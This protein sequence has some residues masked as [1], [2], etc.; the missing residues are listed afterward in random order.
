MA[1]MLTGTAGTNSMLGGAGDDKMSGLAGSDN[2]FGN[3]GNDVLN[4]GA[5]ADDLSGGAGSDRAT[6]ETAAAGVVASLSS[7][8]GNMGDAKGD[9]TTGWKTSLVLP[10]A[11]S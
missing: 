2:L 5:G 4:G 8:T 6:Y 3:D 10:S 11:T 9:T 7:P 1:D